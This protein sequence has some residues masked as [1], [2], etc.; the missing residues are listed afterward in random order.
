MATRAK[1]ARATRREGRGREGIGA[2]RRGG[3]GRGEGRGSKTNIVL[4]KKGLQYANRVRFY[5]IHSYVACRMVTDLKLHAM[6]VHMRQPA[7]RGRRGRLFAYLA[8]GD[9]VQERQQGNG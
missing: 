1:V 4:Q 7:T 6:F 3:E 9:W 2:E 5:Y 8:A